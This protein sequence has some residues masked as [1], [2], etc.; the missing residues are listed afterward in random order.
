WLP[1]QLLSFV[2][3]PAREERHTSALQREAT[4]PRTKP[5]QGSIHLYVPQWV[6]NLPS[7]PWPA[8][9]CCLYYCCQGHLCPWSTSE[10]ALGLEAP[11]PNTC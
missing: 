2:L 1:S 9:S 6:L 5:H 4:A 10:P 8:A 7:S 11:S 3:G